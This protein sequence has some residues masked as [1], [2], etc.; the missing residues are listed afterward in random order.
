MTEARAVLFWK[1][2]AKQDSRHLSA[3]ACSSHAEDAE[4]ASRGSPC[5]HRFH[6][7]SFEDSNLSFVGCRH[8]IPPL[9]RSY[10]SLSLSQ[11]SCNKELM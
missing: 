11:E 4:A 7:L 5:L 6:S 9:S 1:Q 2:F 3:S 8:L 10:R